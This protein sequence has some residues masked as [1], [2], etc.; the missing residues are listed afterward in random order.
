[1][2][3]YYKVTNLADVPFHYS[4][5][6]F[7]LS[8]EDREAYEAYKLSSE[9]IGADEQDIAARKN[10][11]EAVKVKPFYANIG[12]DVQI[13]TNEKR[14]EGKNVLNVST[15]EWQF[16]IGPD[17]ELLLEK[18][19][20]TQVRKVCEEFGIAF[21]TPNTIEELAQKLKDKFGSNVRILT[22]RQWL[23]SGMKDLE[24][25]QIYLTPR[26]GQPDVK[27]V[28]EGFL[29]AEELTEVEA[30]EYLNPKVEEAEALPRASTGIFVLD[31]DG[32]SFFELKAYAK[33]K[34]ITLARTVKKDE[35]IRLI[36]EASTKQ[37]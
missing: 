1:M 22:D 11:A 16:V 3:Q 7:L 34:G 21:T 4:W 18:S 25:K 37:D 17:I 8:E 5:N 14:R 15:S 2:S 23:E 26:T 10:T 6:K 27:I 29:K 28:N 33:S 36:N 20:L 30:Y 19:S 31:T 12:K 32:M 24:R 35:V 9:Y 13:K